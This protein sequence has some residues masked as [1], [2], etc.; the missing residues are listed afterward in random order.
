MMISGQN[1]ANSLKRDVCFEGR[2][3]T[4]KSMTMTM[5]DETNLGWLS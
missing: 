4:R 2:N 5:H 3:Q 1:Q